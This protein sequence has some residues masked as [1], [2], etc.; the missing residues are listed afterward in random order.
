MIK[1]DGKPFNGVTYNQ[2]AYTGDRGHLFIKGEIQCSNAINYKA[3]NRVWIPLSKVYELEN[4]IAQGG[5]CQHCA[6]NVNALI[7]KKSNQGE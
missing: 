1:Y 7:Q 5:I 2:G 3:K 6:K 4:L